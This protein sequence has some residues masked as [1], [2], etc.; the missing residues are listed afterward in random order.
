M[1]GLHLLVYSM[2]SYVFW[3]HHLQTIMKQN[4]YYYRCKVLCCCVN[5]DEHSTN[6][7]S[8]IAQLITDF[9]KVSITIYIYILML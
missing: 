1:S 8:D 6:A 3:F 5:Q 2:L 7:F 4:V 9:F